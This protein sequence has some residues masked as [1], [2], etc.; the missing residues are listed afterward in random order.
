MI[1]HLRNFVIGGGTL[2]IIHGTDPKCR[3][4][5][6]KGCICCRGIGSNGIEKIRHSREF[7]TIAQEVERRRRTLTR[8]AQRGQTDTAIAGDYCRDALARLV[9]HVRFGQKGVVV[10]GVNVDEAWRND[11]V[12]GV[13]FDIGL[14]LR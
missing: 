8:K 13:E 6:E 10:V 11:T 9:C 5:T 2:Q 12:G 4:S 7:I 3:M 14:A 1:A